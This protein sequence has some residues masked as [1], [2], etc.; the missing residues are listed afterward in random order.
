M[1]LELG[2]VPVH[3]IK[4]EIIINSDK[5]PNLLMEYFYQQEKCFTAFVLGAC[6]INV[7]QNNMVK[8]ILS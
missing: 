7:L 6:T 8:L 2:C 5:Q 3:V 4:E 1:L